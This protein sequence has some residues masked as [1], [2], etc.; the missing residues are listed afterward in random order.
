MEQTRH[1]IL[2]FCV[3]HDTSLYNGYMIKIMRL[4]IYKLFSRTNCVAFVAHGW[5][6]G[7]QYRLRDNKIVGGTGCNSRFF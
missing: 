3:S 5:V 2:W 1:I 4:P 7:I 6:L